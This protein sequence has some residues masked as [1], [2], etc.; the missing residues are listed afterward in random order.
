MLEVLSGQLKNYGLS[1]YTLRVTQNMIPDFS[2]T[3]DTE[4]ITIAVQESKINDL[5][6]QL[7]AARAE[8]S[9]LQEELSK[10][11]AD[12]KNVQDFSQVAVK[13]S[14]IFTELKNCACGY[15][16]TGSGYYVVLTA[17]TEFPPDEERET[18][19]R[20]WLM[21]ESGFEDCVITITAEKPLEIPGAQTS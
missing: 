1:D 2:A 4:R 9:G 6:A 12:I 10:M 11:Q 5:T 17:D 20:N 15:M 18:T 13:A 21:T 14:Q 3:D 16:S 8:N 19:I 7:T